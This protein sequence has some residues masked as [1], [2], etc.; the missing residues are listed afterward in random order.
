MNI[1]QIIKEEIDSFDWAEEVPS[2]DEIPRIHQGVKVVV[3]PSVPS[4]DG[5]ILTVQNIFDD[6]DE[7]KVT[8]TWDDGGKSYDYTYDSVMRF[9]DRGGI[10]KVMKESFDWTEE[11][12]KD[13]D[14]CDLINLPRDIVGQDIIV[15]YGGYGPRSSTTNKKHYNVPAKVVSV[16]QPWNEEIQLHLEAKRPGWTPSYIGCGWRF[17]FTS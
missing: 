3:G 11:I 10:W 16:T 5:R 12:G 2:K 7:K 6:G 4:A 9:T 14:V 1:K 13:F 17:K 15:T 8:M